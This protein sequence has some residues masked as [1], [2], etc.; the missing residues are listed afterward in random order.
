[1]TQSMQNITLTT[2]QVLD[3]I[4]DFIREIGIT[5]EEGTVAPGSFLPAIEIRNGGI[6]YDPSLLSYP[7]DLLHEAGHIAVSSPEERPN[8]SGN[9]VE[10][11]QSK[12]GDEMAVLLWTW[13]ASLHLNLPPQIVFH[14]EGYR[15]SSNWIIQ[16]F[17]ERSFIG[18]PLLVWMKMCDG[19]SEDGSGFP[20]ML[21]W[22]R[23]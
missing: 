3:R 18:L 19:V 6:I 21:K 20:K 9:I 23:E 2:E 22:M 8:L 5:V 12:M 14:K 15:G 1:M 11:D 4:I 7:G 13:A 16:Q 10:N 17:T